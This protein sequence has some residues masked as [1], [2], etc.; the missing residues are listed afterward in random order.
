MTPKRI[1]G[2]L[3]MLPALLFSIMFICVHIYFWAVVNPI[4]R[5]FVVLFVAF[6]IGTFLVSSNNENNKDKK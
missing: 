2:Y 6:C 4:P 1:I 3:F 5:T